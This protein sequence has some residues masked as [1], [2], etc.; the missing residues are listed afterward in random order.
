MIKKALNSCHFSL[1]KGFSLVE[2]AVVLVILGLLLSGLLIP[3]SAQR[4]LKDYSDTRLRLEQIREA[5][6]GYAIINGNLPC[7]TTTLDPSNNVSYGHRDS[8]CPLT[9]TSGFLPWKDLGVREVDS[10]GTPRNL[11]S[12]SWNGHWVYR[13][14]PA[15]TTIFT[16]TTTASGNIDLHRSDTT[17][18]TTAAER[19]VAVICST[20]KNRVADGQNASFENVNPIYQDDVQSPAFDDMCIW[21]TRPSLFNRMVA[22]GKLPQ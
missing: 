22:A 12:D 14:D 16:L 9:A 7:P 1:H 11:T 5:L 21:I 2:M 13:V 17:S 4:D 18:L 19:A 8:L 6:Y 20:G 3:L 15:F 10:W